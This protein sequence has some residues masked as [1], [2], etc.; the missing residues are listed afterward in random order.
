[1]TTAVLPSPRS[2]SVPVVCIPL[3]GS[4]QASRSGGT[5]SV[6][7]ATIRW[8]PWSPIIRV[9]NRPPGLELDDD[10]VD[11]GGHAARAPE[12]RELGGLGQ[13]PPHQ[14]AWRA[15]DPPV[16]QFVV[17]HR[18]SPSCSAG[19][20]RLQPV[21]PLRPRPPAL[22]D[23]GERGLERRRLEPARPGLPVPAPADQAGALEHPDVLRHGLQAHRIRLRQLLDRRLALAQPGHDVA[24]GPVAERGEHRVEPLVV[25]GAVP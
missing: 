17:G 23:P 2:S 9:S 3:A 4:N 19:E 10:A 14:L 5:T 25:D 16:D 7:V 18:S 24:P 20:V 21:H 22:L 1:M 6:K 12:L 15:E 13:A 11:R 8:L